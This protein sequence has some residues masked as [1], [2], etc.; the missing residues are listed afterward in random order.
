MRYEYMQVYPHYY[1]TDVGVPHLVRFD[2]D[3]AWGK[4]N[5][6]FYGR[7]TYVSL[8]NGMTLFCYDKYSNGRKNNLRLPQA[9]WICPANSPQ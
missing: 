9:L 7:H 5:T 1:H 8:N 4:R 2:Q 3:Y 6:T